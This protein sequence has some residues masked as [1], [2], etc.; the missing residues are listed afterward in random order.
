MKIVFL[1]PSAQLGGAEAALRTLLTA[2][3]DAYPDWE[4][5]LIVTEDGPLIPLLKSIG[6]L[7]RVI[8]I[9]RTVS[10]VGDS[11]S[12][13]PAGDGVR[14]TSVIGKLLLG[15]PSLV[16]Y[17]I[18]LGSAIRRA[19][20]QVVH[21]NGFK[22]HLIGALATPSRIPLV[23]HI[24]DYVSV[25]PIM[26]RLLRIAARFSRV[27]VTNSKSVAADLQK[28]CGSRMEIITVHNAVDLRRFNPEGPVADLDAL[29]RIDHA[30]DEVVRIGLVATM[31]K[32]KG[33]ETYL[34]ALAALPAELPFRGYVIGGE[35]YQTRGSQ[36]S[37]LFLRELAAQLGLE[38]RVGFT[39]FIDESA[40]V[41]RALDVVVHASTLPEPFGLV[42]VEAMASCRPVVVSAAG[43]AAEI[44]GLCD[45]SLHYPPG[46]F[47][48]LAEILARLIA[49]RSLRE[50]A[51]R[52]GRR[53]AEQHFTTE[54]LGQ[55]FGRLYR[56]LGT[57][58]TPITLH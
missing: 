11:A 7:V 35:V 43:G 27:A 32:W 9:P 10:T 2:L 41:M 56:R 14:L 49:S 8:P 42:I 37:I 1:N 39:G 47:D 52:E 12:G 38:G 16:L 34:R 22:M 50:E 28:L 6:V 58:E 33:H 13:G 20:P 53:C 46:D 30:P 57:R 17:A 54:R 44:A 51:G 48:G 3:R 24:H 45:S 36:V 4:L 31:A 55:E 23:W 5:E 21:S 19:K 40:P 15:T 26:S 18:R 25:R 29:S